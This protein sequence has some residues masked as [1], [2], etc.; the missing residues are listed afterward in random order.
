MVQS[1]DIVFCMAGALQ[2]GKCTRNFFCCCLSKISCSWD[3]LVYESQQNKY[4]YLKYNFLHKL[5]KE[6]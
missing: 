6:K 3:L 2:V 4:M 5:L 1:T